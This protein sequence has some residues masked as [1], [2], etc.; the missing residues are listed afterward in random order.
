MSLSLYRALSI[1]LDR[2]DSE[3]FEH[4]GIV[5]TLS[6]QSKRQRG[7]LRLLLASHYIPDI[8]VVFDGSQSSQ[9]I[10]RGICRSVHS[11]GNLRSS[12]RNYYDKR[13]KREMPGSNIYALFSQRIHR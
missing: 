3:S 11:R 2:S 5:I 7:Q 9:T 8:A 6:S 12:A 1:I 4:P 13:G 10:N